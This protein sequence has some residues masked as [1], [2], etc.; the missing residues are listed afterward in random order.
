MDLTFIIY[1]CCNV[2]LGGRLVGPFGSSLDTLCL[3][4]HSFG[5]S[6]SIGVI[7]GAT[8]FRCLNGIRIVLVLYSFSSTVFIYVILIS[9]SFSRSH[10]FNMSI[11]AVENRSLLFLRIS[12]VAVAKRGFPFLWIRLVAVANR[13]LLYPCSCRDPRPSF[14]QD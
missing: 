9:L 6:G 2:L 14:S 8:P 5:R 3:V 1:T 7:P 13:G 12:L 10:G 4:L 11:V